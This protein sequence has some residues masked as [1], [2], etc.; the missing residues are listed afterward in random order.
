VIAD[1]TEPPENAYDAARHYCSM[2]T[3]YHS[4]E[5][6]KRLRQRGMYEV[7]KMHRLLGEIFALGRKRLDLLQEA[8]QVVR[9]VPAIRVA[10]EKD[11]K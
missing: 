7:A 6:Q 2:M 5:H 10:R 4:V 3:A 8:D 1:P 11:T 9:R